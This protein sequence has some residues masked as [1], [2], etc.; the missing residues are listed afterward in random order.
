[1]ACPYCCSPAVFRSRRGI[2]ERFL[3]LFNHWPY[4][5]QECHGTFFLPLRGMVPD[6]DELHAYLQLRRLGAA[7]EEAVHRSRAPGTATNRNNSPATT[8]QLPASASAASK[9]RPLL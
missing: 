9:L 3:S 7:V 5:C 4:R 1:M 2:L 8:P 6:A